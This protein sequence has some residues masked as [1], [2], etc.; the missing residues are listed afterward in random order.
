M[1]SDNPRHDRIME[2]LQMMATNLCLPHAK[3]M[4]ALTQIKNET[5]TWII[6]LAKSERRRLRDIK[7]ENERRQGENGQ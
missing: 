2:D 1:K 4:E 7:K 5:H 3:R 6:A